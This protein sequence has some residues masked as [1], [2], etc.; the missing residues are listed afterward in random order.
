ML[1]LLLN[2]TTNTTSRGVNL[3]EDKETRD[4]VSQERVIVV[5]GVFA[6]ASVS[7]N[8]SADKVNFVPLTNNVFTSPSAKAEHL[9][10][11]LT[12]QAVVSNASAT[13]NVNVHIA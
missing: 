4:I 1:K 6:G 13:T 8:V 3:E 12:V 11:E 7:I 9:P 10:N 2:A 5:S